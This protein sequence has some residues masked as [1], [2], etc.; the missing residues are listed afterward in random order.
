M[1]IKTILTSLILLLQIFIATQ[2]IAGNSPVSIE[3][4]QVGQEM[5]IIAH[6][7][8]SFPYSIKAS[9]IDNNNAA[10]DHSWPIY[11]VLTPNSNS[12]LAKVFAADKA[13]GFSFKTYMTS[14]PGDFNAVHDP[15]AIYRLPYQDG[16]S[17]SI[18]QAIGGPRTTHNTP[19]SLFAIDFN[20]PEGTPIIAARDGVV[21]QTED[22]FTDGGRDQYYADK[23]N[24][25]RIMHNDGTAGI[26]AHL[27]HK[28]V[29][30]SLGQFVT[31]GTLLGY[32]GSTGFSSGPHLHFVV[33]HVVKTSEG[34]DDVSIPISFYVGS[35]AFVFEPQKDFLVKADYSTPGTDPSEVKSSEIVS[36]HKL[37]V[38]FDQQLSTDI[39]LPSEFV[40][41]LDSNM[42]YYGA[43][44]ILCILYLSF[45]RARRKHERQKLESIKRLFD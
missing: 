12:V 29:A 6:N 14:M 2:S 25:V 35:P 33:T 22:K 26:Y 45:L 28:G 19:N 43:L 9:L 7:N 32:S 41:S 20:M 34:F 15:S 13:S 24:F 40:I 4:R 18:G 39:N 42:L 11:A 8:S 3:S 10:S 16:M 30:V 27:M 1:K 17:F 23:A 31:A 5:L 21:V 37:P 38:R 44:I 36:Q